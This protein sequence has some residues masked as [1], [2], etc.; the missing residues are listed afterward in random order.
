M[1]SCPIFQGELNSILHSFRYFLEIKPVWT[2]LGMKTS[3]QAFWVSNLQ[4]WINLNG[5][6]NCRLNPVNPPW[7][8]L[9]PFAVWLIWKN[10]KLAVEIVNQ[11]MEYMHCVSFSRMPVYKR[12]NRMCY[13]CPPK[14]W[15]KLNADGL[16]VGNLSVVGYGGVVRDDRGRWVARFT[17]RIG[18]TS[19][20][21]AKLWVLRDGLMMCCNLN[22]SSLLVVELDAKVIVDVL[23]KSDYV[24]NVISLI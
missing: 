9:F 24:N 20:F 13:E 1:R 21:V 16:F 6:L 12:V 2:Q 4:D 15:M 10:P 14:G 22:I 7:R 17:R 18:L 8:I 19:S 11:V 3:N 23:C 5:R